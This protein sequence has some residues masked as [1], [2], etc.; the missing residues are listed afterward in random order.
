MATTSK[1]NVSCILSDGKRATLALP[2]PINM[3]LTDPDTGDDL[4]PAAFDSIQAVYASDDGATVNSATFT[5]VKTST[6]TVAESF[7][8]N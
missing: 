5:I 2:A 4:Y 6:T 1:L 7:T 8:G 3:T